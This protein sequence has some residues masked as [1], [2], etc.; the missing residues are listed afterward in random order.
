ML[1][2]NLMLAVGAEVCLFMSIESKWLNDVV[3]YDILVNGCPII[4]NY[5][6]A[7]YNNVMS[8]VPGA[9]ESSWTKYSPPGSAC[10]LSVEGG[11]EYTLS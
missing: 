7:H 6:I 4:T 1:S 8:S 11:K 10:S 5:F 9:I 3:F 2:L